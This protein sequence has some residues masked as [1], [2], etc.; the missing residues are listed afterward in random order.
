MTEG[1][2]AV[3][4]GDDVQSGTPVY[5]GPEPVSGREVTAR[6]DVFAPG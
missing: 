3:G 5:E 4:K 6:S 2:T 1:G